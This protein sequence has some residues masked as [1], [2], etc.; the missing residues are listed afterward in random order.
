MKSFVFLVGEYLPIPGATSL[1]AYKVARELK[2]RGHDVS[3]ICFDNGQGDTHND[4]IDVYGVRVPSY[5]YSMNKKDVYISRLYKLFNVFRYPLKSHSLLNR[6][7]KKAEYVI[8]NKNDVT[9]VATYAP[10]EA[11]AS[12]IS[13]KKRNP[14]IKAIFYSLDT[15]SNE[16]GVGFLPQKLRRKLGQKWE[17]RIFSSVDLALI[18]ECHKDYYLNN[19][20]Q[21]KNKIRIT[22]FPLLDTVNSGKLAQQEDNRQL[23]AV[24]AGTLYKELRNPQFMCEILIGLQNNIQ[25]DAVIMGGGDCTDLLAGFVQESKGKIQYMGKQQQVTVAEY[26]DKATVLLSIGNAESPMMPSKI[27]EYMATGKP[28]IHFYSWDQDP[29]RLPLTIY[30]NALLIKN[31]DIDA[32][33]KIVLF[34][35]ESSK[36]DYNTVKAKFLTSTP[37][38]SADLIENL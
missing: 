6:Y 5:L 2:K 26:L 32:L 11:A 18:M 12:T 36:L 13:I 24:Y 31:N 7:I 14:R 37:E 17:K 10:L 29:C 16:M 9:V 34:L 27:F 28:I 38:F 19:F 21:Y 3:I 25:L 1:C 30:G 35:Q 23:L 15:L 22:S 20:E 33:S 4:G 8:S